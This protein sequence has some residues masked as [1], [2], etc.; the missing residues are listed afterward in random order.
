MRPDGDSSSTPTGSEGP[1]AVGIGWRFGIAVLRRLPTR[2][3]SRCVGRLATVPVPRP[4]RRPLYGGFARLVGADLAE[5]AEPLPSFPNLDAFFV[6]RLRPGVHRVASDALAAVSPVD[7]AVAECGPLDDGR[8]LQV[9]GL[10][11]SAAELLGSAG[12][13]APYRWGHFVTLYLSPR[14]YHRIHAPC[15]GRLL[16]ARHLPGRLL[17]VN[18]PTSRLLGGLLVGN[19]RLVCHLEGPLGRVA[20]VAVG[21]FNV[22]R[23]TAAFDPSWSGPRGVT[24][25]PRQPA[26]ERL[27]D[28]PLAVVR[29][30]EIMAF[31]LG[32]TVVVLFEP[33]IEPAPI[34]A[35][36]RL[37]V[38]HP[39]AQRA[40]G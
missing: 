10:P 15:G 13:A 8:L 5:V 20:V 19:E 39:I 1:E 34:T 11:Y 16:R 35:G 33:G 23:I 37:R 12:D 28:P 3:L 14:D 24:N 38:G 7:A 29:G 4:L 40:L 36:D 6:R 31:H 2:L 32:S 17:P 30:E 22:G 9:K 25:R 18:P 21:A 27:Y 26:S